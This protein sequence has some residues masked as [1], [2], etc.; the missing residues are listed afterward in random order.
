MNRFFV[1]LVIGFATFAS[2]AQTYPIKPI[3]LIVPY[4]SGGGTDAQVRP[5]ASSLIPFLEQQVIIDNRGGGAT[6]LGAA[7]AAKALPDGYTFLVC[8]NGTH[9]IS[10]HLYSSLSY[11]PLKDFEPVTLI[12]L[13]PTVLFAHANF[14]FS[15]VAAL[16]QG[17]KASPGKYTY[18]TSGPGTPPHFSAEI[19]M[20]MTNIQLL[21]VPYKGGGD[22]LADMIAG[23]VDMKFGSAP[24]AIPPVRGGKLK[25]IAIA[26]DNRW[27]DLPDVPTFKEAGLPNY[28]T[29]TWHGFCAP[30]KTPATI[31]DRIYKAYSSAVTS[32][33]L[34]DKLRAIGS[35]PG[36]MPPKEF[37]AFIRSEYETY[38]KI[39]RNLGLKAD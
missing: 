18:V 21:Q 15:T 27:P 33:D 5:V 19:F 37:A 8:G 10:P 29:A 35:S 7:A 30:A 11:D 12:S 4:P 6:T 39:I 32:G 2:Y 28:R 16:I 1:M 9:A 25:A 31:I 17:A 23:R 13:S 34:R 24:E 26:L 38:G 22:A 36:G 20:S 3:R 14:P